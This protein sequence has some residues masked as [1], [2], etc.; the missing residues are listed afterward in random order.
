MLFIASA[1]YVEVLKCSHE[2]AQEE[3]VEE[4]VRVIYARDEWHRDAPLFELEGR[5]GRRGVL[6]VSVAVR[7]CVA[8]EVAAPDRG[9]FFENRLFLLD[10]GKGFGELDGVFGLEQCGNVFE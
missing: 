1:D 3:R 8:V 5:C 9:A 2:S 10:E 6:V 7:L 4:N